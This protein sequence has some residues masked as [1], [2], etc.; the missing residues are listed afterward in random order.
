TNAAGALITGGTLA[1]AQALALDPQ[2]FLKDNDSHNFFTILS[3]GGRS[4]LLQTGAT[5]TNVN[6]L[7][8]ICKYP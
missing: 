4:N 3:A 6:D 8:L 1:R 2:A 5:G 7:I